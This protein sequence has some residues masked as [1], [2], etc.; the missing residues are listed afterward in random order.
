MW[1]DFPQG[2]LANWGK[3]LL[4][5]ECYVVFTQTS[6]FCV[7]QYNLIYLIYGSSWIVFYLN[8]TFFWNSYITFVW[9]KQ[10]L[11][12]CVRDLMNIKILYCCYYKWMKLWLNTKLFLFPISEQKA[13]V[14]RL[15][16]QHTKKRTVAIGDG[17]NDV[18][19]IQAASAGIGLV[20]KEGKQ[21]SL[22]ADW[23]LTQFCH[24]SRLLLVHGRNSYKR[25]VHILV[26]IGFWSFMLGFAIFNN[27]QLNWSITKSGKNPVKRKHYYINNFNSRRI[28]KKRLLFCF[29][30]F[31]WVKYPVCDDLW[32]H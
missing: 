28:S 14:V 2:S 24:I 12:Y 32:M 10:I 19:M 9:K 5:H 1:L 26:S 6:I 22:A 20:G 11:L 31:S 27:W 15:I 7:I 16:E 13:Q 17:G 23:S 8:L 25:C 30:I 29:W 3:I 18:P 21:A 4:S